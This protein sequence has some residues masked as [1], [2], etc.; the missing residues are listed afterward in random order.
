MIISP[1]KKHVFFFRQARSY[2][3]PMSLDPFPFF[4]GETD[5]LMFR[6]GLCFFFRRFLLLEIAGVMKYDTKRKLYES[7][8]GDHYRSA[9]QIS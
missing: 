3:S 8:V 6:A 9:P 5:L 1:L 4:G 2:R 7:S